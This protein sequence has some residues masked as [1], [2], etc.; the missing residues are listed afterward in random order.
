MDMVS[1]YVFCGGI[2]ITGAH[3]MIVLI[4]A[5]NAPHINTYMIMK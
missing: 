5:T 4:V 1:I 3:D 2:Y